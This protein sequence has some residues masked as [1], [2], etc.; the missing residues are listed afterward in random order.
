MHQ[1]KLGTV[2]IKSLCILEHRSLESSAP[3]LQVFFF[4]SLRLSRKETQ[5]TQKYSKVEER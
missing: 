5:S 3:G 4:F 1:R 2:A